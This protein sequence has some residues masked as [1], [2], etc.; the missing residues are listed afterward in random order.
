M[1]AQTLKD[2][3]ALL[4]DEIVFLAYLQFHKFII[5]ELKCPKC[6]YLMGFCMETYTFHCNKT[7]PEKQ[8]SVLHEC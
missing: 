7:N 8:T 4:R 6:K 1:I 3:N 5:S 2:L